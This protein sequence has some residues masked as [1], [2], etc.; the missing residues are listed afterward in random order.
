MSQPDTDPVQHALTG[1]KIVQ[2]EAPLLWPG[3]DTLPGMYSIHLV[4]DYTIQQHF[5]SAR[6]DVTPFIKFRFDDLYDGDV[7]YYAEK[8]DDDLLAAIRSDPNVKAV[9]TAVPATAA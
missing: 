9:Y 5:E 1:D 3:D 4:S 6:F 7:V 2:D 8:V